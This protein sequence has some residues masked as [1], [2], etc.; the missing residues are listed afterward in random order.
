MALIADN[1]YSQSNLAGSFCG[2]KMSVKSLFVIMFIG[3]VAVPGE[4]ATGAASGHE[5]R[6]QIDYHESL[7]TAEISG[8]DAHSFLSLAPDRRNGPITL[9]FEAMGRQFD[10]NLETNARLAHSIAKAR[11]TPATF[12]LYRGELTGNSKSWARITILGND[13]YGHIWDGTDLYVIEPVDVAAPLITG[14]VKTLSGSVIYR[15]SDVVSTG[16]PITCALHPGSKSNNLLEYFA[17]VSDG[18]T[19]VSATT[20]VSNLE[21]GI[22]LIAD[23]EYFSQF[24]NVTDTEQA[25][26]LR[27]N[28]VDGVTSIQLGV[29][30]AVQEFRVFDIANDPFTSSDSDTLLDE[31]G[32]FKNSS[33]FASYGLAHLFTGRD[34]DGTVVGIAY[35]GSVCDSRFG[36]GL[37][38]SGQNQSLD[39][40]I[41]AHEIGHNFGA[42]HD[43]ES[44]SP[45]ESITGGFIMQPGILTATAYSQCSVNTMAPVIAQ[46]NCIVPGQRVDITVD[47]TAPAAAQLINTPFTITATISNIGNL[48]ANNVDVQ[49]VPNT[50]LELLNI[51]SSTGSCSIGAGTGG[52]QFASIDGNTSETITLTVQGLNAAVFGVMDAS[53]TA[54][55]DAVM[56]N[57]TDTALVTITQAVDLR[58]LVASPSSLT[59]GQRLTAT[60]SITNLM[61]GGATGVRLNVTVPV[62]LRV[63]SAIGVGGGCVIQTASNVECVGGSL[64]SGSQTYTLEMTGLSAGANV[65]TGVLTSS[66]PDT[67]TSNNT[68]QRTVTISS[69]TGSTGGSGGG[70]SADAYLLLF[71]SMWVATLV[72]AQRERP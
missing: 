72:F 47:L 38:Q 16:E 39:A 66:E 5:H 70:G 35:V 26:V 10:L 7:R 20:E 69:T 68:V 50:E 32:V 25:M 23:F 34:L 61:S 33:T 54:D 71:L 30:F 27:L 64:P 28:F 11:A 6:L 49:F 46:A 22:G 14:D 52:C 31:L 43:G 63:E 48:V 24:G 65:I 29:F 58:L 42:L 13:L 67:D 44:G 15:F 59:I 9:R 19:R 3:L 51:T 57:N 40:V 45:C 2:T 37:I 41:S 60:F 21:V 56:L 18:M 8:V 55:D 62:G 1:C 53:V 36:S 4:A 12:N 17:H